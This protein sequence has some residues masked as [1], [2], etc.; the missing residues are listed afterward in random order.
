[1]D[2]HMEPQRQHLGA[3]CPLLKH[4]RKLQQHGDL[5]S[6]RDKCLESVDADFNNGAAWAALSD[7]YEDMEEPWHASEA[8]RQAVRSEP[9]C[10]EWHLLLCVRQ[11]AERLDE[12]A[13]SAASDALRLKPGLAAAHWNRAIAYSRLGHEALAVKDLADALALDPGLWDAVEDQDE[14]LALEKEPGFPKRPAPK[15]NSAFD[16]LDAL[17]DNN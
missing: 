8:A 14:L 3:A 1:L 7:I 6:A 17:R 16:G 5:E 11:L 2:F 10:P 13:A 4:A 9:D 15:A 12:P